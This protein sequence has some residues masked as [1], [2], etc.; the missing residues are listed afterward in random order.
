[1]AALAPGHPVT[2]YVLCTDPSSR[3]L[4]VQASGIG[5]WH[6]PG[7]TVESGESP[8]N[9]ARREVHEELGLALDLREDDLLAIEWAQARRQGARAR[10]VFLWAG[11]MLSTA[12]TDKI[13]LQQR[14]LSAW[15]WATRD[16]ARVI[17]HPAVA[18]RITAPLQ[19]PGRVIYQEARHERK[20]RNDHRLPEAAPSNRD[21]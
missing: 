16:Q 21:A 12:D 10:L 15:R 8:L 4:V 19:L 2:S 14:E 5:S 9:A 20:D 3:L 7:G 18:A 1:M 11:P 13:S 6:L 17:L